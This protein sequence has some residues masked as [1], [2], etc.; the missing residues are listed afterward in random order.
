MTAGL[1]FFLPPLDPILS[2]K[3]RFAEAGRL[4]FVE[5]C[6]DMEYYGDRLLDMGE[7]EYGK[8]D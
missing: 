7:R 1:S 3:G 4:F 6:R 8:V 5:I 2:Q